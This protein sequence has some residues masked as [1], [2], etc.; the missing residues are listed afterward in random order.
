LRAASCCFRA[1]TQHDLQNRETQTGERNKQ[2]KTGERNI[3]REKRERE[4]ETNRQP[5]RQ[6]EKH[7][8]F[9]QLVAL[10][11]EGGL[12]LLQ[13][14]QACVGGV[15]CLADLLKLIVQLDCLFLV[16]LLD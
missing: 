12:L 2:R 13:S 14:L 10:L 6:A 3:Q 5:D 16:P 1:P 15:L 9:Q 11:L 8:T 7:I 4:R